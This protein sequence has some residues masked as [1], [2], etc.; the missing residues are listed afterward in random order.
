MVGVSVQIAS[1]LKDVSRCAEWGRFTRHDEDCEGS[2][3]L[4]NQRLLNQLFST[5]LPFQITV[6][7]SCLPVSPSCSSPLGNAVAMQRSLRSRHRSVTVAVGLGSMTSSD[8]SLNSDETR[9]RKGSV[10]ILRT[11]SIWKLL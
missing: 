8:R 7:S 2:D 10:G 6:V 5:S 11:T 1:D 3:R 9:T 4:P